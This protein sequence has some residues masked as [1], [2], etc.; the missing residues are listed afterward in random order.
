MYLLQACRVFELNKVRYIEFKR[1]ELPAYPCVPA[2]LNKVG[3]IERKRVELLVYRLQNEVLRGAFLL[4]AAGRS[5]VWAIHHASY[6][7]Y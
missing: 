3:Y 2:R 7:T 4:V 1:V 6:N 5:Y